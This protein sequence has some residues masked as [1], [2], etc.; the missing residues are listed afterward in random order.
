MNEKIWHDAAQASVNA[1]VIPMPVNGTLLELMQT[2]LNEEEA[3]FISVFTKPMNLQ[4]LKEKASF[5]EEALKNILEGLMRKGVVT[6]IP[7]KNTGKVVY[8]LMPPIPGLFE[9]TLMRGE[10]G[11]KEKSWPDCSTGFSRKLRIWCRA[12]MIRLWI[13]S[14]RSHR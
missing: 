3:Q 12:L 7:S 2:I 4:E 10:T 8:R 1:G 9:F 11:E 13:S 5:T 14:K 6:G